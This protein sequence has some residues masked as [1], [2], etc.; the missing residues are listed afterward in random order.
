MKIHLQQ[1]E[2]RI[3]RIIIDNQPHRN[4][5][6]LRMW[7]E[8]SDVVRTIRADRAIRVVIL[9]GAGT[10]C[11][12]SGADISEFRSL[13]DDR[14]GTA[15]YDAAIEG[16]MQ[17]LRDIEVPVLAQIHGTC[18]GGGVAL[19]LMCDLRYMEDR[20]GFGIPAGKLG[21]AYHPDWIKRLT[22]IVGPAAASEIFFT[23]EIHPA[24]SAAAW[25]FANEIVPEGELEERVRA[26]AERTASLAPMTLRAAKAAILQS[27]EF[28]GRRNWDEALRLARACDASNDYRRGVEFYASH[29]S[30]RFEGD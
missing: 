17:A 14:A 20:G 19:A 5:L 9:R 24:A 8:L 18:V 22:D 1:L 11:F 25:G 29:R 16:A 12:S 28:D 2:P 6:T 3:A 4:A 27:I 21:I 15:E 10:A 13:R 7:R 26:I 23:A 30:P